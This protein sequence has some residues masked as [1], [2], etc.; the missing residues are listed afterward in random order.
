M[1]TTLLMKFS[2]LGFADATLFSPFISIFFFYPAFVLSLRNDPGLWLQWAL[3]KCVFL[4][5][6]LLQFTLQ[7]STSNEL[8]L[9]GQGSY[10]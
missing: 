3:F 4:K 2:S 10:P 8:S 6:T 5:E 7:L 1:S 9:P